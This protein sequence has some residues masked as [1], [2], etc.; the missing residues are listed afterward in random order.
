M[1]RNYLKLLPT[2]LLL[3]MMVAC[4]PAG[5]FGPKAFNYV[6]LPV[7]ASNLFGGYS[8]DGTNVHILKQNGFTNYS[9]SIRLNTDMTFTCTDLPCIL[10]PIQPGQY[11]SATGKWRII[12]NGAISEVE[13]YEMNSGSFN[14]NAIYTMPVLNETPPHGL[15][16][17]INHSAGYYIRYRRSEGYQPSTERDP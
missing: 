17:T 11:F 7:T 8:F 9:G 2:L 12:P 13:F 10:N 15:E 14:G 4:Q 3:T 5:C 1:N 16:L 6:T